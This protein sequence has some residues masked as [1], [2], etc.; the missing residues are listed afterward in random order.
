MD[1]EM[2]GVGLWE[3]F[4]RERGVLGFEADSGKRKEKDGGREEALG[5][6]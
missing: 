2:K 5:W 4:A 6:V 3:K 1:R